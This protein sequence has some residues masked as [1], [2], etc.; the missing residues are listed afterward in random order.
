M[1]GR[2]YNPSN[3]RYKDYGDRG[4]TVCD[5]WKN[6]FETF[7]RDMGEKPSNKHSIDRIDVN[8]IYE[9]SNCRWVTA[10]TQ[11]RNTRRNVKITIGDETKC[12]S[13]WAKQEGIDPITL[14]NRVSRGWRGADL[15]R[16]PI[17]GKVLELHGR[18]MTVMEWSKE[19]G[20]SFNTIYDR[21]SAGWTVEDALC[22]RPKPSTRLL[23][24]R[25]KTQSITCW[26][27]ELGINASTISHRLGRGYSVEQ[28]L[29]KR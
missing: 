12:V 18:K 27:K 22:T 23:M 1:I 10:T 7:F 17:T 29:S 15:L 9:P 24:F 2:C 21:L 11:A 28:A 5:R 14:G 3:P 25:G 20:I 16:P 8:G 26:A 19:T 4:I 6:S 13:E